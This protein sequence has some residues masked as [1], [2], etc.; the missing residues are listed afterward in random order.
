[1][2]QAILKICVTTDV[3]CVCNFIM[4]WFTDGVA[5][6]V[7]ICTR[8]V[9]MKNHKHDELPIEGVNSIMKT[10]HL[11][12]R[13]SVKVL[14]LAMVVI[15]FLSI[16]DVVYEIVIAVINAKNFIPSQSDIFSLFGATMTTLIGIEIFINV[17]IYLGSDEIPVRLVLATAL[18]AVARK[19][20]VLDFGK[21]SGLH[22]FAIGAVIISLGITYYLLGVNSDE[23]SI[24]NI[25]NK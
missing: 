5:S 10:Y 20:I 1:M 9:S 25:N 23:K 19:I 7:T 4:P 8:K 6:L 15:I 2:R 21:L 11:A 14:A 17:R 12:I 16:I 18:M 22:V 3:V 13:W 24:V